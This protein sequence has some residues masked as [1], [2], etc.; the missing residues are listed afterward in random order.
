MSPVRL[1]KGFQGRV[2][3]V[4]VSD[5]KMI[6]GAV[7]METT[8]NEVKGTGNKARERATYTSR[9]DVEA[10]RSERA[11]MSSFAFV[12]MVMRESCGK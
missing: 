1:A 10:E 6:G 4:L 5:L 9:E 3:S 8:F 12:I 2:G 11:F 7:R